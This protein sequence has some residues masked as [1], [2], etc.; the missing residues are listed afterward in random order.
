MLQKPAALTKAEFEVM[1]QHT[2]IGER[3]CG[4]LRSLRLVRPIVRHHHERLDGSGYPD[5]L[6]GDQVPLLAQIVA[7]AD[8][9]D[10]ITTAR[11]YRAASLPER[12][13]DELRRDAAMGVQRAD[14]VEAFIAL[15]QSDGFR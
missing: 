5:G 4:N 10:A 11:P 6:R 12:A 1:K 7:V 3:L 9:Y 2:I 13:Y 14:L 8:V 15:S